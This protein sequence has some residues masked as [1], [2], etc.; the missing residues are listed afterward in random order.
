MEPPAFQESSRCDV[1]SC[2]FSAFRRRHHC[3]CCGRTLCAEHSSNQMA[4][5]QFGILS[6]VRVCSDCFNHPSRS[7]KDD[8]PASLNGANLTSDS[9]SKLDINSVAN[10]NIEQISALSI[11]ECKCGMPLCICVAPDPTSD[12]VNF[13][14][15]IASVSKSQ[16]NTKP[17]K[18]ET[19]IPKNR[20]PTGNNKNFMSS[21]L[22]QVSANSSVNSEV[23]YEVSGEGLREAIKSGDTPAVMELLSK[24]IDAN[25]CDKQGLSLL[26]LA[27]LF[28]RTD[29]AFALMKSGASLDCKNL[30]GETPLDCAPATLQYKMKQKMEENV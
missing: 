21:S 22:G 8:A 23:E 1:C 12:A 11:V 25:Y 17:K 27:A 10:S 29:I 24:G 19:S 15:N 30:Q 28:N 2:S 4:L 13:Q 16:T 3:R 18:I 5:P 14:N 7:S 9:V 6:H 20:V 26:H